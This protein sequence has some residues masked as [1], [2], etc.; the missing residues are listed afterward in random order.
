MKVAAGYSPSSPCNTTSLGLSRKK[1]IEFLHIKQK[2]EGTKSMLFTKLISLLS[3]LFGS[4]MSLFIP[5]PQSTVGGGEGIIRVEKYGVINVHVQLWCFLGQAAITSVSCFCTFNHAPIFTWFY[6][7]YLCENVQY[8]NFQVKLHMHVWYFVCVHGTY[9]F[10]SLVV[11]L[12]LV[13]FFFNRVLP[14][15]VK[16]WIHTI[17]SRYPLQ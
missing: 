16:R 6:K 11:Q 15:N 4:V 17:Q 8:A 3:N 5:Y 10:V 12:V 7:T 9:I 14:E 2:I 1:G 13:L